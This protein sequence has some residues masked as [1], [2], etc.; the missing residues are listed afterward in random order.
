MLNLILRVHIFHIEWQFSYF[1][2]GGALSGENT[3]KP[4]IFSS[5]CPFVVAP[6]AV[7]RRLYLWRASDCIILHQY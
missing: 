2:W 4:L 6:L 7:I 3:P 5:E 1:F